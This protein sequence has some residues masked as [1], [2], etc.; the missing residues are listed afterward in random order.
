MDLIKEEIFYR[1]KEISI[2]VV[3]EGLGA[4]TFKAS[5]SDAVMVVSMCLG[6]IEEGEYR[7]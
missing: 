5:H 3:G 4:G 1:W 7:G 2:V 6:D